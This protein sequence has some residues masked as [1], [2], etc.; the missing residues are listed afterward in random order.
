MCTIV[1]Q[2]DEAVAERIHYLLFF[3]IG[4][5][6]YMFHSN[7][8]TY[9]FESQEEWVQIMYLRVSWEEEEKEHLRAL[10]LGT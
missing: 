5:S 1:A 10:G 3:L 8:Y 4:N 9:I 7:T 6:T 2:A